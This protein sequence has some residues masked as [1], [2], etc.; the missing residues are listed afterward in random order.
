MRRLYATRSIPRSAPSARSSTGASTQRRAGIRKSRWGVAGSSSV[1]Q[2]RSVGVR[3]SAGVGATC[4]PRAD[5][6]KVAELPTPALVVDTPGVHAQP[7]RHERPR[8]P[9][10]RLRP[11]VKAHKCTSLAREQAD[12][13]HRGFTCATPREIVGMAEAGLGDDLLLAN[14]CVDATRLARD[15]RVRR[16]RHGRGRLGADDRR[17]R[18]RGH[19]RGAGRRERRDAAL[20]LRARATAGALADRGT[21]RRARLCAA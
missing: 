5:R 1:C 21:R 2:S 10:P 12:R 17:G 6:M 8:C 3:A 7:R 19:P 20:R 9:A 16:A 15:G 14:E 18:A 13:G 11:H 4:H